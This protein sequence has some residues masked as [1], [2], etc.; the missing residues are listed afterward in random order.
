MKRLMLVAAVAAVAALALAVASPAGATTP[1]IAKLEAQLQGQK[2]KTEALAARLATLKQVD[3]ANFRKLHATLA[4]REGVIAARDA[5][6]TQQAKGAL[7]AVLAGNASD[8][9]AAVAAIWRAFPSDD[10]HYDRSEILDD[11]SVPGRWRL[12]FV[13]D[14]NCFRDALP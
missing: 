2:L 4:Q 9:F 3:A 13:Y 11:K 8:L 7:P 5:Q 12:S 6:I 1:K 14:P 10:C